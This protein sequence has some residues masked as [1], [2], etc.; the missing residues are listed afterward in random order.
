MPQNSD[1]KDLHGSTDTVRIRR[2]TNECEDKVY[3][4]IFW[5]LYVCMYVCMQSALFMISIAMIEVSKSAD[6][7]AYLRKITKEG[8]EAGRG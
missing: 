1:K 3:V 6:A 5:I 7:Y 8:M 2:I 4:C